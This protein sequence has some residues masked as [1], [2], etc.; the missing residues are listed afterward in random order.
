M[1]RALLM[2]L[3]LTAV[4]QEMPAIVGTIPNRDG[5]VITFT[6]WQGSCPQGQS[7]VYTQGSGGKIALAG[8]WR[9]LGSQLMVKWDDGD[10]YSY[11]LE[12]FTMSPEMLAYLEAKNNAKTL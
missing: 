10:V 4:A 7:V 6:S 8:C 11:S 5:A 2:L 9:Y 12:Q 3:P 1:K